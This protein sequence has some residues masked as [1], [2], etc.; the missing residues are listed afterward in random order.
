MERK[1]DYKDVLFRIGYFRNK[2]NLSCR[3]TSLRLG[4]SQSY[5][6]RIERQVMEIKVSTLL[7][8]MDIVNVSPQEFFYPKPENYQKDKEI[9]DAIQKLSAD[10]KDAILNLANKLNKSSK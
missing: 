8:F 9:F 10:D 5:M 6:N 7:D 2:N 1:M 3:E 4:A